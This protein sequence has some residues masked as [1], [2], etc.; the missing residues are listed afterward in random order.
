MS[1]SRFLSGKRLSLFAIF[2]S[3]PAE[4]GYRTVRPHR[5]AVPFSDSEQRHKASRLKISATGQKTEPSGHMRFATARPYLKRDLLAAFLFHSSYNNADR[6]PRTGKRPT[7]RKCART[8]AAEQAPCPITSDGAGLP[9]VNEDNPTGPRIPYASRTE[10]IGHS[11]GSFPSV[12]DGSANPLYDG[13]MGPRT[14]F[15][16]RGPRPG[17]A[18]QSEHARQEPTRTNSKPY[19]P[20]TRTTYCR[21]IR[22]TPSYERSARQAANRG[23]DRS[24][25]H[26]P[27]IE[28]RTYREAPAAISRSTVCRQNRTVGRHEQG[29]PPHTPNGQRVIARTVGT[30]CNKTFHRNGGPAT[31][32][33]PAKAVRPTERIGPRAGS[34]VTAFFPAIYRRPTVRFPNGSRSTTHCFRE[35]R[36]STGHVIE[37]RHG[38]SP[39]I[40]R[41]CNTNIP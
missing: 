4:T 12:S 31:S 18:R 26:R 28:P 29:P 7:D 8:E 2:V 37:K 10:A 25:R 22:E 5:T 27:R 15:R 3:R 41:P 30:V 14:V 21:A 38:P 9:N 33:R 40:K 34:H 11:V 1:E 16:Q 6:P 32:R 19:R 20:T 39:G 35:N 23:I 36:T 17:Y 13:T 24:P